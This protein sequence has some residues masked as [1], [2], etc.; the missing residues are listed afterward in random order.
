MSVTAAQGF[1][2]AGVAVGLKSTG[3]NDVAVV[4][5]GVPEA[6]EALV[7]TCVPER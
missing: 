7:E 2:A 6:L 5:N 4:V 1:E 3:A